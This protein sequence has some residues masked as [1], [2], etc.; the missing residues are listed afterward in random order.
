MFFCRHRQRTWNTSKNILQQIGLDYCNRKSE[1][2][3][4]YLATIR[5][6]GRHQHNINQPFGY[7]RNSNMFSYLKRI[8]INVDN[9]DLKYM[10]EALHTISVLDLPVDEITDQF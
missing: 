2:S 7:L 1:T 10:C 9:N 3:F 5:S 8:N 6:F 4:D